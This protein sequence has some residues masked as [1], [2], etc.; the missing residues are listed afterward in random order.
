MK[1]TIFFLLFYSIFIFGNKKLEK[2]NL[3]L[4]WGHGFQFAG[5]YMAKEKG[6]YK[7][8]GMDIR[9]IE[10]KKF[11]KERLSKI[12]KDENFYGVES[13]SILLD[14]KNRNKIKILS[15]IFQHSPLITM[16]LKS[17]GITTPQQFPNKRF[18][19]YGFSA[20]LKAMLKKEGVDYKDIKYVK[21]REYDYRELLDNE[22]DIIPG[23]ITSLPYKFKEQN[24][25]YHIIKPIDY[26]IDFYGD[27][28]FTSVKEVESHPQRVENFLK[29][30]L[31]GW[32]YAMEHKD[33]TIKYILKDFNLNKTYKQLLYEAN[34]MEKNIIISKFIEIGHMNPGRWK[35]IEKILKNL[36]LV[37]NNFNINNFIYSKKETG[38]W[39]N[40]YFIYLMYTV[41]LIT[42]L[43][44]LLFIFNLQL[45]REVK[46]KIKEVKEKD[47]RFRAIFN[48]NFQY[49]GILD[50][51]GRILLVNNSSLS[52]INKKEKD[53][54]G[55][56]FWETPWFEHSVKEQEKIK[57]SIYELMKKE[58]IR[59]ETTHKG[60]DGNLIFVDFSIKIAKDENGEISFYIVEGR[61]ITN[62]KTMEKKINNSQKM[63]AIGVLAGG[64]AHDFNNII[65][66]I[67]V[68]AEVIKANSNQSQELE[69]IVQI[70]DA[71]NRAKKLVKRIIAFS[72]GVEEDKK[73]ID[74]ISLVEGI[75]QLVKPTIKT[76]KIIIDFKYKGNYP[77]YGV[78]TQIEQVIMNILR[79]S[80]QALNN[81]GK[82]KINIRNVKI[83]NDKILFDSILPPNNYL[84]IS[85]S[86]NGI[87]IEK[88]N[89]SRIFEPYFSTKNK[90]DGTGLGLF[91]VHGI[92]NKHDA[93]IDIKS[94]VNKGTSFELYFPIAKNEFDYVKTNDKEYVNINSIYGK[95]ILFIDDEEM[96]SK[97]MEKI[98]SK[99]GFIVNSFTDPL[100]ALSHFKKNSSYYDIIITDQS[101]PKITG[102]ELIVKVKNIRENIPVVLCSGY[103][104]IVDKTNITEYNIDDYLE[105]PI[106]INDLTR[107]INNLLS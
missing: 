39:K 87:G 74:L 97:S 55:R 90:K 43:A 34:I 68:A 40:K 49:T 85:I 58:F 75:I 84:K 25:D 3:Y 31:K 70:I 38:I 56:Y 80:L 19:G 21:R 32:E 77:V 78:Y 62:Y 15:V 63:E 26:G 29:A 33:E 18:L 2:I 92:I 65:S 41:A 71:S 67:M 107:V 6:Y 53:I 88:N 50:L 99:K 61:D 28:I 96:I 60:I 89:L 37:D 86:D 14:K 73:N 79:N 7:N 76:D 10:N 105:K 11:D 4:K 82:V 27:L 69:E 44:F 95:H 46:N 42:I 23:Y 24:I 93:F 91:I 52:I 13:P 8:L 48:N 22:V 35:H 36:N 72:K 51:S 104:N 103:N 100:K 106:M 66:G 98:L 12:L 59:F 54:L 1:I 16:T 57:N 101:M 47:D 20:E 45:N 81:E 30:S 83:K 64:I 17:S 102:T 5:Y 9:F 94:E